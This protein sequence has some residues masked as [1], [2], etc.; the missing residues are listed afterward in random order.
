MTSGTVVPTLTATTTCD[1][2]SRSVLLARMTV[3]GI[4]STS[5]PSGPER[6]SLPLNTFD[7]PRKLATNGDAGFWK[8]SIGVPTCRILPLR[9]M[10]MR[11]ATSIASSWSWVTWTAVSPMS[12]TIDF[13]SFLSSILSLASR[14]R[15]GSSRRSTF[16]SEASARARAALCCCPPESSP[17]MFPAFLLMCTISIMDVASFR[18]SS[19]GHPRILGEKVTLS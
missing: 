18:V 2:G 11:S 1:P 3:P 12:L 16:E 7:L 8:M 9:M 4:S 14:A 10:A 6:S 17:G 15:S 5:E 19:S 13:S